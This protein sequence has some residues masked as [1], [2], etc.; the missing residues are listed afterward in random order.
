[1]QSQTLWN[2]TITENY[3][4]ENTCE[5]KLYNVRQLNPIDIP[6]ELSI[7]LHDTQGQSYRYG[8]IM[9]NEKEIRQFCDIAKDHLRISLETIL[10]NIPSNSNEA[11]I[12][13]NFV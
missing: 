11:T 13:I 4:S 6:K 5:I 3:E 9:L 12:K 2:I 7:D 1:M 10:N 8:N